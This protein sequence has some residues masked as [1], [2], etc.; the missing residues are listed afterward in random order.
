M[1]IPK[2]S[3]FVNYNLNYHIMTDIHSKHDNMHKNRIFYALICINNHIISCIDCM[4]F[5]C[6]IL[7]SKVDKHSKILIKITKTVKYIEL[8][9]QNIMQQELIILLLGYEVSIDR[10]L[11]CFKNSSG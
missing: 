3:T 2:N 10:T 7:G 5:A 8:V 11:A 4:L 1:I 9:I 6:T